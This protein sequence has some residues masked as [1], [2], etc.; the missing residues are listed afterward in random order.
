MEMPVI[1]ITQIPGETGR[2]SHRPHLQIHTPFPNMHIEQEHHDLVH[3]STTA[4]KL[5]IDQSEAFADAGLKT[6]LR[7]ANEHIQKASQQTAEYIALKNAEGEQLKKIEHGTGAIQRIAR[8]RTQPEQSELHL[9]Y[10]PKHAF[11]VSFDFQPFTVSIQANP[12]ETTVHVEKREPEIKVD[13]WET[14]AYMKQKPSLSFQVVGSHV[15][16]TM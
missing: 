2:S 1:H 14:Q 9:E 3:I 11:R 6:P 16:R 5:F 7:A 12:K 4:S 15:N 8:E 13:R 10:M